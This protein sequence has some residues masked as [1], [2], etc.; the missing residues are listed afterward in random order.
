MISKYY[1]LFSNF[2][3]KYSKKLQLKLPHQKTSIEIIRPETNKDVYVLGDYYYVISEED[4]DITEKIVKAVII[5][6]QYNIT[7]SYEEFNVSF[8]I[9]AVV[10]NTH[11]FIPGYK[12]TSLTNYSHVIK[13]S[14]HYFF[15]YYYITDRCKVNSEKT[16]ENLIELER[17]KYIR[18]DI[19]DYKS[20]FRCHKVEQHEA[21]ESTKFFD[22]VTIKDYRAINIPYFTICYDCETFNFNNKMVPYIIYAKTTSHHDHVNS[23]SQI[24]SILHERVLIPTKFHVSLPPDQIITNQSVNYCSKKFIQWL[25]DICMYLKEDNVIYWEDEA[26]RKQKYVHVRLFGFNNNNFDDHFII[27]ELRKLP[28]ITCRFASRSNK[29]TNFEFCLWDQIVI[30]INDLTVWLPNTSLKK[31]CKDLKVE[32]S[33]LDFNIVEY[34]SIPEKEYMF[35]SVCD[36]SEVQNYIDFVNFD[37]KDEYINENGQVKLY[38]LVNYYCKIDVDSTM[39]LHYKLTETINTTLE[40]LNKE[41]HLPKADYMEYISVPQLA[42]ALFKQYSKKENHRLLKI[43][44]TGLNRFIKE[45]YYGG[46][47]NYACLGE[48]YSE[49]GID[50]MD[51]T[52][53]YSLT[54]TSF[55]PNVNELES[56]DY[57]VTN[58]QQYQDIL[59]RAYFERY[60]LFHAKQLHTTRL[61]FKELNSIKGYFLCDIIPPTQS[62]QLCTFAPIA[63]RLYTKEGKKLYYGNHRQ[64]QKILST[65]QMRTLIFFGWSVIL[66]E[67]KYNIVFLSTCRILDGYMKFVGERKT[68]AAQVKNVTLK[69]FWK[70]LANSIYGRLA[71]QPENKLRLQNYRNGKIDLNE[72]FTEEKWDQSFYY[73]SSLITAEANDVLCEA[74]YMLELDYIYQKQDIAFRCGTL[75]YCDTDSIKMSRAK[76]SSYYHFN[77]DEKIGEWN[78]ERQNFDV[79]WKNESHEDNPIHSLIIL[80]RKVYFTVNKDKELIE[81][82][83]KGLSKP[84]VSKFTYA[85]IKKLLSDKSQQFAFPGLVK[86]RRLLDNLE[87]D[88]VVDIQLAIVNKSLKVDKAIYPIKPSNSITIEQNSDCLNK[89]ETE[90]YNHFL[91]FNCDPLEDLTKE[92]V[93][94]DYQDIFDDIINGIDPRQFEDSVSSCATTSYR[95]EECFRTNSIS[96]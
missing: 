9:S 67:C 47:S 36:L 16:V 19:G 66:K 55:F 10:D 33:K 22:H 96:N 64:D 89:I 76:I 27:D 50:D 13:L 12:G 57:P 60:K 44:E 81:V 11:P 18:L 34:N 40:E 37:K 2:K 69:N 92:L 63:T 41:F 26:Q 35:K 53:M 46:R 3:S 25:L 82:R 73:I 1:K 93:D 8:Q 32:V 56:I 72:R 58:L 20:D 39:E 6:D 77:L 79:T 87:E 75:L 45:S 38:E 21:D 14:S 65:V 86:K 94:Y 52:S 15:L 31:A 95:R 61:Y 88:I 43:H 30:H 84:I 23:Y 17:N 70:L 59:D 62:Y 4:K 48:Y 42:F 83:S 68:A 71:K 5:N 85:S 49:G 91:E 74:F 80:A 24:S 7:E 29:V 90:E 54:M 28:S 78:E 51:V